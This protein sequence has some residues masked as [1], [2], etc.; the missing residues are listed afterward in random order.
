MSSVR[1]SLLLIHQLSGNN[2]Y[3]SFVRARIVQ[4]DFFLAN[5]QSTILSSSIDF[6]LIANVGFYY[7][8]QYERVLFLNLYSTRSGQLVYRN[9]WSFIHVS[10]FAQ[11]GLS[12]LFATSC[13]SL[14]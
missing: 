1:A 5:L 9:F 13:L 4:S 6:Q 11:D 12:S 10:F 2:V 7:F 8:S 3:Y 14:F